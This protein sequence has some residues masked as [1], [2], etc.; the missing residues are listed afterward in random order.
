[1]SNDNSSLNFPHFTS[2]I[3]TILCHVLPKCSTTSK[4][5]LTLAIKQRFSSSFIVYSCVASTSIFSFNHFWYILFFVYFLSHVDLFLSLTV[6]PGNVISSK[7]CAFLNWFSWD[8][9]LYIHYTLYILTLLANPSI[10]NLALL[11]FC[12]ILPPNPSV[13]PPSVLTFPTEFVTHWEPVNQYVTPSIIFLSRGC[14]RLK[15]NLDQWGYS[16][17]QSPCYLLQRKCYPS[18]N[19]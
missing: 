16:V 1:M 6:I 7:Y 19:D 10:M 17:L 9:V 11:Y 12:H 3:T 13:S 4:F 14:W 8:Y 2:T 18:T 5:Y 15:S